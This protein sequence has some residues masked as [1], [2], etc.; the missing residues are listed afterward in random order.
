[1]THLFNNP[2]GSSSSS[3]NEGV[4][5]SEVELLTYAPPTRR[6]WMGPQFAFKPFSE[7]Q[8]RS[9]SERDDPISPTPV[10][11]AIHDISELMGV[12]HLDLK[13]LHTSPLSMNC[14]SLVGGKEEPIP[15]SDPDSINT[16]EM[17]SVL[18]SVCVCVFLFLFVHLTVHVLSIMLT[19]FVVFMYVISS[20][21]VEV[22]GSWKD[23][24]PKLKS[25]PDLEQKILDAMKDGC[26]SPPGQSKP[27][28]TLVSSHST[29]TGFQ[30]S[31]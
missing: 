19:I 14:L 20:V 16:G 31:F 7:K 2:I 15:G 10:L 12:S 1:M 30:S 28:I 27:L 8:D 25:E 29:H 11:P 18:L 6:L 26:I 21:G 9:D 4:W 3:L 23:I 13:S 24:A 5:L 22:F 17:Y